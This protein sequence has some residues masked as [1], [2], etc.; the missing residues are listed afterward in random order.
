[1]E[2]KRKLEVESDLEERKRAHGEATVNPYTGRPYTQ[3][4]YD[5]LEKRQGGLVR[6][7][8]LLQPA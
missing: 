4:Y 5:I 6:V 3:R 7:G 1:M 2:R 8:G